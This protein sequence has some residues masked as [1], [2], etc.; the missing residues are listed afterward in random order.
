MAVVVVVVIVVIVVIDAITFNLYKRRTFAIDSKP[1]TTDNS[2]SGSFFRICF[3]QRVFGG[4][5]TFALND[6]LPRKLQDTL[7]LAWRP[8]TF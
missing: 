8:R 5:R 2:R 4:A 6:I 3:R 1:P 7:Y